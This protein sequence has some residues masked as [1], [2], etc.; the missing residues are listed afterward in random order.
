[1]EPLRPSEISDQVHASGA[2][3]CG[4][5]ETAAPTQHAAARLVGAGGEEAAARGQSP[6]KEVVGNVVRPHRGLENWASVV[7]G[8]SPPGRPW[9]SRQS[10]R[11]ER[12]Q[13][14]D[15]CHRRWRYRPWARS[16][17]GRCSPLPDLDEGAHSGGDKGGGGDP[18]HPPHAAQVSCRNNR[19]VRQAVHRRL[20]E[21][22]EERAG[23]ADAVVGVVAVEPGLGDS[24]FVELLDSGASRGVQLVERPELDGIRR[25]GLGARRLQP[26]PQPV[27]A[28]RALV[29]PAI[30]LSAID[31]AEG[32]TGHAVTAAVADLLLHDHGPEFGAEQR[33]RRAHVQAA[34]VGA[35]LADVGHHQPAKVHPGRARFVRR[36]AGAG[37]LRGP[38][39][40]AELGATPLC[41]AQLVGDD[42]ARVAGG[43]G[44]DGKIGQPGI[45]VA[46]P[47]R[48]LDEGDVSPGVAPSVPL[49]SW[50][51]E[52]FSAV[53]RDVVPLL[54]GH[55]AGLAADADEVSVKNP[56]VA[57]DGPAG[58]LR[59]RRIGRAG[60]AA[61]CHL[62]RRLSATDDVSMCGTGA[63]RL[64][65]WPG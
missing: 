28:Q 60:E 12:D 62:L 50:T 56:T 10:R 46:E 16:R 64:C 33:S 23:P 35:V 9:T 27:V 37:W 8:K 58:L 32:A 25:A 59:P 41:L 42:A 15:V 17:P 52:Q 45:L 5:A 7:A 30:V 55:L 40:G 54:A 61:A 49:L 4:G 24:G 65:R 34:G 2:D 38:G 29:G 22:Q 57:D 1:M 53:R 21:E 26:V 48:L 43:R 14:A 19:V 31:H 13:T 3:R 44:P 39:R 36:G 20:V 51:S 6:E 18:R 63:A 11:R 47:T